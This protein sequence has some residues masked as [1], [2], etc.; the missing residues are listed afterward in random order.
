MYS[1]DYLRLWMHNAGVYLVPTEELILFL[2][3]EIGASIAI[4]IGCGLGL[5]GRHLNIH[6]TDS[7]IQDEPCVK[8]YYSLIGQPVIK[9]PSYVEKLDAIAAVNKYK[10]DVVIGAWITRWID[11]YIL[12]PTDGYGG[13]IYGVKEN[14]LIDSVKKYIHIGTESTHKYKLQNKPTRIIKP[15]WLLSRSS[16]NDNIIYIWD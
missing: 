12:P 10:P 4:E 1:W 14:L 6:I 5:L 11:P 9:Y 16:K 2:K 13:S 15:S 3:D 8:N 7:K